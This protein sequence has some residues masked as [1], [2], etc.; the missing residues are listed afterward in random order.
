VIVSTPREFL[1]IF[2]GVTHQ[3][4]AIAVTLSGLNPNPD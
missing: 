2:S 3:R 1:Q 4:P